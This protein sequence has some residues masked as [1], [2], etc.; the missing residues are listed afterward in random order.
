MNK[1]NIRYDKPGKWEVMIPFEKVGENIEWVGIVDAREPGIYELRVIANHVVAKTSGR[2]TIRAVVGRGAQ[3]KLYG[4]IKI[5]K[6]AQETNDYL[7]IRAITLDK[8]AICIAEPELEIESNNVK[9]GHGA[10]VGMIDPEQVLYMQ[11][12][13]LNEDQAREQIVNGWLG[14]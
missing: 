11:S 5:L 12:R 7:E 2:I 13:G 4:K 9:A 1:I 3:V 6:Q 10:S 8:S 14:V